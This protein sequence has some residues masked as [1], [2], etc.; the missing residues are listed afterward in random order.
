[1][2]RE[3][4]YRGFDSRE[5]RY[6]DLEYNRK[7]DVARIHTYK[8]DGSYNKQYLVDPYTVGEFTGMRDKRGK[9]IFEGDIVRK[10]DLTFGLKFDGVVVYNS[11]IGC[12]RIHSEN[13]GV[14]MRMGF[15]ASDVYNDGKCTVPVKYDY[16]VI[17]NIYDN[18]ELL[19][20]K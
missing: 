17:G 18:P 4:E 7:D 14:T 1:M 5:W 16:E 8:D 15:E 12:F 2:N 10:R 9:K 19:N 3:V 11:E 6:G 20:K 13:N